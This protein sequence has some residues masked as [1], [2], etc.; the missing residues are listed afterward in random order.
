MV[1]GPGATSQ[2]GLHHVSGKDLELLHD[3]HAGGDL[4]LR[5][6]R[7]HVARYPEIAFRV[8]GDAANADP[9]AERFHLGR[10]V[11]GKPQDRVRLG[12]ANP[13]TI[14]IINRDAEG[15]VQ[16][17]ELDDATVLHSTTGKIQQLIVRTIG[18]PDVT[19]RGDT[20]A[21]QSEELLLKGG[22]AFRSD[23]L[24]VEIHNADFPVETRHPNFVERHPCTPTDAVHGHA[25]EAGDCRR[26]RGPVGGELDHAAT[27]ALDDAGLRAGHP[28]LAAPEVAVHVET[29]L[30][31]GVVPAARKAKH[32]NEVVRDVGKI[33]DERRLAPGTISRLGIRFVEQR[34]E[35]LR[36]CPRC[37]GDAGHRLEGVL[38]CR[39]AGRR[40]GLEEAG[41]PIVVG[42]REEGGDERAERV[43]VRERRGLGAV[44]RIQNHLAPPA[45]L[46]IDKVWNLPGRNPQ[47]ERIS[48]DRFPVD[49]PRLGE[50]R[51]HGGEFVDRDRLRQ[52]GPQHRHQGDGIVGAFIRRGLRGAAFCDQVKHSICRRLIDIQVEC[53]IFVGFAS[54]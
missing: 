43:Q 29:Q 33:R 27:D 28:V 20:D 34:I 30:A 18:N 13:D 31:A 4:R 50:R 23:R 37:A 5:K 32:E 42:H 22:V 38:G 48:G 26:E 24:A 35:L 25:G 16:P 47:S 46:G 49:E 40:C 52:L 11:G 17:R 53:A 15:R 6:I 54:G 12:V 3:G 14:L 39:S 21:H 1:R 36:V 45:G 51:G 19:V 41:V 10:I 9:A 2:E 8:Q 7:G 44:E